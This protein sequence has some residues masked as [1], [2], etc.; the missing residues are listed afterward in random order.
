MKHAIIAAVSTIAIA[1]GM[2]AASAVPAEAATR[3]ANCT[4][5][6]RVYPGGVARVGVRGNKVSGRLESFGVRPTFSTALYNANSFSDRDKDGIACE[7]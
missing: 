3:Y 1:G 6:N 5:L 7:R 2:L 4:A